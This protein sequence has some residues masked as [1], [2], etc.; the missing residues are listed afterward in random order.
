MSLLTISE[1]G[2]SGVLKV[3]LFIKEIMNVLFIIVPIGLIIIM[4]I[5]LAKAVMSSDSE[6]MKKVTKITIKRLVYAVIL[7]AIPTIVSI[8]NSLLGDLGV[9]YARC[10]TMA[11]DKSTIERLEA[12][13][14][15]KASAKEAARLN[16]L[17]LR[18]QMAETMKNN[19]QL[20]GSVAKSSSSNLLRKDGCDG[21]VYYE[22]GIFYKPTSALVPSNGIAKTKGS[23]D[24]G[25][26]KYFYELLKEFTSAAKKEGYTVSFSTTNYGAWRS[27][28]KQQ[29]LY[30][31]YTKQNCNN[32]NLAAVPGTSNH[33]WGIAS[34]LSYNNSAAAIEWAHNNA[35]NY[36]L[37]FP[38]SNENWHIEPIV[39]KKDDEKVKS[40]V[41]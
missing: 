36:G 14:K 8:F 27:F 35:K 40:C 11:T 12:D 38:L 19:Q 23:G 25:Y 3:L 21:V 28:E 41:Q 37:T 17:A 32:G 6:E 18:E 13:E 16:A 10:F 34:D 9:D 1:C 29:E 15:Q 26:N 33:G 24:Y 22:N 7:F 30:N 5:D 31:C 4:S 39:I 20:A 2:G